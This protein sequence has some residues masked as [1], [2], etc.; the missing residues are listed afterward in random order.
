MCNNHLNV[1][2]NHLRDVMNEV[3]KTYIV[4]IINHNEY[5]CEVCEPAQ[6]LSPPTNNDDNYHEVDWTA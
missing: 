5:M 4:R 3:T 2:F 1:F 6:Y